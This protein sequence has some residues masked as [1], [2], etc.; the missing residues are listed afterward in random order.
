MRTATED[1]AALGATEE[2]QLLTVAEAARSLR[3][4]R[5]LAYELARAYLATDG[6]EGLPVLKLGARMR[7]PRWA[8]DALARTGRV[9]RLADGPPPA[10]SRRQRPGAANVVTREPDVVER[11]RVV[12]ARASSA[13]TAPRRLA[14]AQLSLL[15]DC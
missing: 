2:L 14:P 9:V 12:D 13:R 7:V 15:L 5:S 6:L 1:Q 4:G 10:D 8:L 11:D 3:I